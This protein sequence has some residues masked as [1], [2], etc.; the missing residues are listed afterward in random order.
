MTL[1]FLRLLLISMTSCEAFVAQRANTFRT[2]SNCMLRRH[3][4]DGPD[5]SINTTR[6]L[7]ESMF[8]LEEEP[9][10]STIDDLDRAGAT[11]RLSGTKRRR[12]EREK[13]ILELLASSS[14]DE[15]I[16]LMWEHWYGERGAGPKETLDSVSKLIQSMSPAALELAASKLDTCI[17]EH[18]DWG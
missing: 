10:S 3:N 11:S 7:L 12:L 13:G 6:A 8:L 5:D 16:S 18:E 9:T 2:H 17:A 14:S 15:A 4:S 1:Q